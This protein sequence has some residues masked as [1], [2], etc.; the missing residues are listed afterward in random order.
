MRR[1]ARIQEIFGRG[2]VG[3]KSREV[4]RQ[5]DQQVRLLIKFQRTDLGLEVTGN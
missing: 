1:G 4:I 3:E 2:E 5:W